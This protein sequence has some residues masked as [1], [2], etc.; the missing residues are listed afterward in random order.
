MTMHRRSEKAHKVVRIVDLYSIELPSGAQA[1]GI[2]AV[3][4]GS[5]RI[6]AFRLCA[7]R[8]TAFELTRTLQSILGP[9]DGFTTF[10]VDRA[11]LAV[12][13]SLAEWAT[14][15]HVAIRSCE[16]DGTWAPASLRRLARR[17]GTVAE[18]ERAEADRLLDGAILSAARWS[19]VGTQLEDR[20]T[21]ALRVGRRLPSW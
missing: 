11:V 7:K 13:A 6:L 3:D 19:D 1:N 21:S 8:I 15:R 10:A 17:F 16:P 5:G 18:I 9:V 2:G 20:P 4:L 14:A 12:T